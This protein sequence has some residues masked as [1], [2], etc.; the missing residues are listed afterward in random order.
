VI[1]PMMAATAAA[2][3]AAYLV[4]SPPIYDSLRERI[5]VAAVIE[6]GRG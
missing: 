6:D 3:F 4:R 2:V 5:A 1:V